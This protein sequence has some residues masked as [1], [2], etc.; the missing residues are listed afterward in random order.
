MIWNDTRIET[1]SQITE[2]YD[3]CKSHL[4]PP[5]ERWAYGKE[6]YGFL[7]SGI[8]S[9][10]EEIDNIEIYDDEDAVLFKLRWS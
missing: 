3:W 9:C 5:G 7:G 1:Y 10:P 6:C 2:M 4:G 8:I